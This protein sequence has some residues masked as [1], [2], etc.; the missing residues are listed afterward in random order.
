[1]K[2]DKFSGACNLKDF[3]VWVSAGV[4]LP[5][6]HKDVQSAV[7]ALFVKLNKTAI[8]PGVQARYLLRDGISTGQFLVRFDQ[9]VRG[10][11]KRALVLK[12]GSRP[13]SE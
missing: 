5:V 11:K 7:D 10:I 3:T 2:I 9:R 1:V 4:G 6:E 12:G 8:Q 13:V